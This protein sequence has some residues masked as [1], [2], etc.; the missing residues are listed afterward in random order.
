MA[1]TLTR[2]AIDSI[3]ARA[4]DGRERL[5]LADDR[6]PGLRIRAGERGAKWSVLARSPTGERI[7]VP[8][9][10]WPGVGIS[11][12]R[13]A[14]RA[15]KKKIEK[16]VNPNVERKEAREHSTVR[17]LLDVY[18]RARLAGLRSG[19]ATKLSLDVALKALL[20]RDPITLTRRD[21]AGVIDKKAKT[22]PVH[23]NRMLA[24]MRAFFGWSVGR[25]HMVENP[26]AHISMPTPETARERTPVLAELAEIWNAAGTLGYPFGAA[27]R[28]MMA[29]GARREEIAAMRVDEL[30]LSDD[31]DPPAWTLP[32]ERSKNG[33]SIRVPLS[34]LARDALVAALASRPKDAPLVF[35]TTGTT[36]VSGWSKAK[37]R[38][39]SLIAAKRTEEAA[40]EGRRPEPLAPW[41]LHDL[42]RSFA[43]LACDVLHIDP[44]VADR[45]LNHV[46]ASTTSTIGRVYGRSE[47]FDQRKAALFAWSALLEAAVAQVPGNGR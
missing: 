36:S 12:A 22:A 10:T 9:G 35:T 38:L 27:V 42:R 16:G 25:G 46:G 24:Y 6:E 31:A 14:A 8:L 2:T 19:R 26:A 20:D 29:T 5:E 1:L 15:A 41:R 34:P 3:V 39:D 44:A 4:A 28:L 18:D 30:D 7:R 23:A 37:A 21:V 40:K 32:A 45:C 47:M 17:E 13:D 43:T 33:R 11:E